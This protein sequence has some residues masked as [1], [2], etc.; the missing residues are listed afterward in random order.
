MSDP[1]AWIDVEM[2]AWDDL[3]LRRRRT[4][5]QSAQGAE[6]LVEGK[7][8]INFGSNDYLGLAGGELSEAVIQAVCEI[9]TG[10]GA[11][12]LVTG[13]GTR[14]AQ[15]ESALAEFEGAEGALLFPTGF[16]AN[17]GTVAALAG[18]G[19][20]I[21]SDAKNHASIIDGCR[22]SGA[23]V[24]VYP[25]RDA[26][27]VEMMLKQ[28][29]PF[30][31]RMIVTDGLFSM[32][33]DLAPLDELAGLAERYNAMLLVDEAHATGVFGR[34]GRGVAEYLGVE[35]RVHA[36]VGTLSKALGC[37]GGFVAG[38]RGLIEWLS[39]KARPYVFSTAVPEAIAAAG[40]RAL[41][42]VRDDPPRRESL[43]RRAAAL[44]DEL[45]RQGWNAGHSASQIIPV[46][47]GTADAAMQL[48]AALQDHGFYV[49]GIRPPTVPQGESLL[50]ISVTHRHSQTMLDQLADALSNLR[51]HFAPT[52]A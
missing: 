17:C 31:R 49:P 26:A 35:S 47:I 36:R 20:V 23:R 33:G 30:R 1:F 52:Q 44:R 15:L 46:Y 24:V 40:L 19:D 32:D 27:Y 4:E 12:P 5:R 16:A 45:R 8:L 21:L 11:S 6:I 14:H 2:R 29:A 34:L 13:R 50:R 43:L 51:R 3:G 48:A 18:K 9:G 22:L 41:Q 37:H 7:R 39:N 38:P 10:S 28:A 25:H 42:I